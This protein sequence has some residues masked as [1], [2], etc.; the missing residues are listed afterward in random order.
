MITIK[1]AND[2]HIDVL[3]LLGTITYNESHGHY[4]DDKEDLKKYLETAFSVPKTDQDVKN[5]EN[6]FYITYLNKLPIG[7]AKLRL[8]SSHDNVDS[9]KSCQLERIYILNEFIPLKIGQQFLTF[10]E[11]KATKLQFNTMWLSV[12]EENRRALRFYEKNDFVKVGTSIF[13][14]NDKEYE[15]IVLSKK[16][17]P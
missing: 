16:I 17:Q 15:N 2:K 14:V 10:L 8:N 7:Y 5:P 1:K 6:L 3:A 13:T 9:K 4:I 12:Y 11:K